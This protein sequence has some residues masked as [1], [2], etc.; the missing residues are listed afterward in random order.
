MAFAS[1]RI[2]TDIA[3][4][5]SLLDDLH[6]LEENK[7]K[8]IIR[9]ALVSA[10]GPPKQHLKKTLR[11]VRTHSD[12]STGA[13]LRSLE[14][15]VQYPSERKPGYG[16]YYVGVDV[17]YSERHMENNI[18]RTAAVLARKKSRKSSVRKDQFIGFTNQGRK[19]NRNNKPHKKQ[20]V[21]SYQKT[22]LRKRKG[23]TA[24]RNIPAMYWHLLE[25]GF[26]HRSGV[27]FPGDHHRAKAVAA[28]TQASLKK[29]EETLSR[30]LQRELGRTSP[31]RVRT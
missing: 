5:K 22:P 20:F 23:Q 3:I 18:F 12:Q 7:G 15:K 26:V 30:G 4:P 24:Q 6:L 29:F 28:T 19:N 31:L 17:G 11:E 10:T 27:R 16:Y 8:A 14:T 13:T 9:K 2:E 1:T 25:D 21:K